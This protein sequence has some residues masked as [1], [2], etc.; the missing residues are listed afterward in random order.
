MLKLLRTAFTI[1]LSCYGATSRP[2]VLESIRVAS[3]GKGFTTLSGEK[4]VPW[5][6]NYDHDENGRLLEDYWRQEWSKVEQDFQEMKDL[7]ANVVRIHLQVGRFLENTNSINEQSLR[8][9]R[10]LTRLAEERGLYLDLTG[11]GCYHKAEVPAWYDALPEASRWEAQAVFW[12]AIAKACTESP[13]VFAYDL[14]NEPVA[15]T[16]N[17]KG[18]NWLGPP[19]AGKHFVQWIAQEGRGRPRT[20]LARAWIQKLSA[21]IREHDTNH[22]ITVGLVDWSLDRPGLSSGFV[23]SEVARDLDFISVHLYPNK[24]EV[25][26]AIDVLRQFAVGKPVLVEE[27]F[28]LRC[29]LEEF[30]QFMEQ[31]RAIAAGWMGFYWGKTPEQCR[32]S[33]TIG[34]AIT[35]S[36]L[37]FFRARRPY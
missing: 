7:G 26:K 29:S 2:A 23:P 8:Q 3:D 6:F 24:D 15:P 25:M 35:L 27:T 5:G 31:S 10:R 9:L 19:F 32:E 18:T 14:M 11:L 22:L 20:E 13:A 21:A 33:G 17:G 1:F 36:W 16:P 37:E 12:R 28:P 30:G 34:D 4:F